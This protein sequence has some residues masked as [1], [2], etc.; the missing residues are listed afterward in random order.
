MK[1]LK[2]INGVMLDQAFKAASNNLSINKE[3]INSLNVYPVPDGD[4]GTNMYMTLSAASKSVD[5]NQSASDVMKAI[6][7]GALMGARGNSGVILSQILKGMYLGVE[8]C[9]VLDI[10]NLNKGFRESKEAAYKAVMKP[11]E[12]TILTVVR[13]VA[14]FSQKTYQNYDDILTYLQDLISHGEMVLDKT[15]DMLREL[16]EAGVV[17]AGGMGYL[18]ILKGLLNGLVSDGIEFEINVDNFQVFA[19]RQNHNPDEIEFSYCTEFMIN[20]QMDNPEGF[21]EEISKDADSVIVV[22]DGDITKVHIHTNHPGLIMERAMDFGYLS[23]IKIDNMKLQAIEKAQDSQSEVQ[24][25]EERDYDFV[26]VSSGAGINEIFASLGV[27]FII[28]GGQTMNPS[29]EDLLKAVEASRAKDIF[30]FPNNK[31]ILMS[32]N[33]AANLSD[34]KVHV[35]NSRHIPEAISAILSFDPDLGPS[36][37]YDQMVDAMAEVTSIEVT[38][39][40]RDSINKGIE[41]SAGDYLAL[42]N[43]E[44]VKSGSNIDELLIDLIRN[45]VTDDHFLI[46]IYKGQDVSQEDGEAL[47]EIIEQEY[48]DLDVEL[49]DGGQP[50]YHYFISIE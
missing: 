42:V 44:I 7:R 19:D 4:T 20:G 40:V 39:A 17:D 24:E 46:S 50:I 41:I 11:T 10:K 35:L 14:D 45:I 28:E 36:E 13:E 22:S 30:L 37:N 26:V 18:I 3:Y 23:D 49:I 16:K 6:S 9:K 47:L 1:Q 33:Q 43:D 8:G 2:E 21:R 31:N 5:T 25:V 38:Y 32:A 29:T 34:K 15:P 12:G 27:N 48:E